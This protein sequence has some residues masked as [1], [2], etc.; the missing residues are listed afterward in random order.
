MPLTESGAAVMAAGIESAAAGSTAI[1]NGI[2]ARNRQEQAQKYYEQNL[3]NARKYNEWLMS[4]QYGIQRK[5]MVNAGIN[6]AWDGT[7]TEN[8]ATSPDPGL[9]APQPTFQPLDFRSAAAPIEQAILNQAHVNNLNANTVKTIKELPNVDAL[10]EL[11]KSQKKLSDNQAESVVVGIAKT[12]Q[13]INNLVLSAGLTRAQTYQVMKV[14]RELIPAQVNS[15]VKSLELSDSQ[16]RENESKAELNKE[17]AKSQYS[18]R[19]LNLSQTR[20]V[21]EL[22]QKTMFEAL[23]GR[24]TAQVASETFCSEVS[25]ILSKNALEQRDSDR[26]RAH[27]LDSESLGGDDSLYF[28]CAQWY[29]E[30][31]GTLINPVVKAV[32]A[33]F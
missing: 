26:Q 10:T 13:E 20:Q 17:L 23:T 14:T 12:Q 18:V 6:P 29:N 22:A 1:Y 28:K 3:Q 30:V 15:F 32:D 25:K 33:I 11:Y 7:S 24:I 4:A 8:I 21:E 2:G 5:G 27:I 16:I 19:Q 9:D 31:M